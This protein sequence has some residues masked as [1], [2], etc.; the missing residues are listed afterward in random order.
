[1]RNFMRAVVNRTLGRW[2]YAVRRLHQSDRALAS[3]PIRTVIDGGA[4]IGGYSREVRKRHPEAQIFAFEPVP[5]LFEQLKRN[6]AGDEKV[7]CYNLA[8]SAMSGKADFHVFA[9]G[10]SSS[11]LAQYNSSE[12][13]KAAKT[14]TVEV[15]TLDEW[16]LDKRIDPAALLKL[17][18]E[19]C[20]LAALHGAKQ[21]L[22]SIDFIELETTFGKLRDGQPE[23]REIMNFLHEYGF[24]LMDVY[25]GIMDAQ[26]GLSKWADVLFS[27][28]S[29]LN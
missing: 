15:T 28:R 25:P 27:R 5:E 13:N 4:N 6:F 21:I 24:E 8:L 9:D 29:A 7:A 10:V 3:A 16:S 1:M 12:T 23:L 11:L 2:G 26:T 17:D 19:G 22:K 20:E 14:I 18:L